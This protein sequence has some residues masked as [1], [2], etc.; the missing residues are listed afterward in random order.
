MR[1]ARSS[2]ATTFYLLIPHSV[3]CLY[4][5][6]YNKKMSDQCRKGDVMKLSI[7]TV[8]A[9]YMAFIATL[10]YFETKHNK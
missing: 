2:L 5:M 4:K 9:L 6:R 1:F 8:L 3:R 7:D 10:T